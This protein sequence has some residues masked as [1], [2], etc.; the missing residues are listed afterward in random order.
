MGGKGRR[1]GQIDKAALRWK[2]RTF[3]DLA[4]SC[5]FKMAHE[6]LWIGSPQSP[7]FYDL[8]TDDPDFDLNHLY[9]YPDSSL[10]T[11]CLSGI[12]SA[13]SNAQS[14][15]VWIVA[16]D[17]PLI[18]PAFFEPIYTFWSHIHSD[19]SFQKHALSSLSS[20][21]SS[22]LSSNMINIPRLIAYESNSHF[23]PLCALWHTS[24]Y[25]TV[26]KLLQENQALSSLKNK[27]FTQILP[28]Q[29]TRPLFNLNTPEDVKHLS[30]LAIST[31][32]SILTEKLKSNGGN[33]P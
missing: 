17:L 15:W 22:T 28:I 9:L 30:A 27:L 16:C 25:D 5:G 12:L 7:S 4:S 19:S 29:N 21:L 3:A 11:G 18:S 26:L 23:H 20:T 32:L 14:E 2:E 1:L 8:N 6:V 33:Q 31:D 13:L 10:G 24:L